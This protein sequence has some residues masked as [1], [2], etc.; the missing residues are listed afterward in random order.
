ME[1]LNP[2][3]QLILFLPHVRNLFMFA[4]H[5]FQPVSAFI[6]QYLAD[7]SEGLTVTQADPRALLRCLRETLP[8]HYFRYSHRIEIHDFIFRLS[9]AAFPQIEMLIRYSDSIALHPEWHFYW[10]A[11]IPFSVAV[12]RAWLREG[13][14]SVWPAEFFVSPRGV[15]ADQSCRL[16]QR[17]YFAKRDHTCYDLNAFIEHRPDERT[18]NHFIAYVKIGGLWYLCDHERVA[19]LRPTE[20]SIP[21]M[22]SVLLYYRKVPFFARGHS[23][24]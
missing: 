14:L 19:P 4:P 24:Q 16:I 6:E 8:A 13:V 22:R 5:T 3:L 1:V 20:I 23:Y 10:D 11:S 18:K 2:I 21:L 7:Q 9:K 12:D 15:V 17:Q